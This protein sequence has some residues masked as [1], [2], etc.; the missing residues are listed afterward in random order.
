MKNSYRLDLNETEGRLLI[1]AA[2]RGLKGSNPLIEDADD[3]S[4]LIRTLG[5][6]IDDMSDHCASS[7]KAV[8]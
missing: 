5:G 8:V 1:R 7:G 2:I 4:M 6:L 3:V